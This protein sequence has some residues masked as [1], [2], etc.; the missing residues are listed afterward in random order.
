MNRAIK[1]LRQYSLIDASGEGLSV[2]RLVQAVVRDRLG[3]D[4]RKGWTE[5]V[6]R[7]LS[8]A[9]TFDSDDVQTWHQCSRLLPH[10]L[11]AAAHA[12]ILEVAP[13]V[14]L[15]I[16]NQTGV[17]LHGRAEFAEAKVLYDRALP[18]AEEAYGPDHP[19]V[20]VIV[21]NLGLVLRDLGD[22]QGAKEHYER[23]LKIDE[24]A[25]GPVHPEVAKDVINL[26]SVLKALGDLKGAKE[27]YERALK[28]GEKTY[29][30][31][32]PHVAIRVSNLGGVLQDLGDRKG[33]KELY[34]RA[35]TIFQKSLGEDHLSTATVRN[36][37]ELLAN[38]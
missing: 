2:H 18:L 19:P 10:A 32:H 8:A 35:L 16:L 22:L 13:E 21:N 15:H 37:L 27:H 31:D 6:V 28:I 30:P 7:L 23:A 36:N 1:A 29:G 34:E 17:Y 9:F 24:E 20:A 12:G 33:A 26:G 11:A 5:T 4:D 3:E 38:G 14:T 25:Y